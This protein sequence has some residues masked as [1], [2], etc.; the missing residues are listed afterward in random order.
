MAH[1]VPHAHALLAPRVR[2]LRLISLIGAR[3]GIPAAAGEFV[4]ERET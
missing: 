3:S 4:R 2:S 1:D